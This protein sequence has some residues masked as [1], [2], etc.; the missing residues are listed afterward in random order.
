MKS[1]LAIT[2]AL[3]L[4]AGL[5]GCGSSGGGGSKPSTSAWPGS[6]TQGG[7]QTTVCGAV[8]ETTDLGGSVVI[9]AG[10]K[11]GTI[12]TSSLPSSSACLLTWDVS[13]ASATLEAGQSCALTVFGTNATVTWTDGAAT[14][15]GYTI[16]G[17]LDG[18]PDNGCASFDQQFTLTK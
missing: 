18:S 11:P 15:S 12:Q 16:S 7:T 17:A 8:S 3:V 2:G 1:V 6:W 10:T 5:L 9:A 4:A 14:L 13:G